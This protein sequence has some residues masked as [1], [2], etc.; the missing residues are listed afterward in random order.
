MRNLSK[1][2]VLA[3]T[4][5]LVMAFTSISSVKYQKPIKL[6]PKKVNLII[7]KP[8]IEP[9]KLNIVTK[10]HSDFLDAIG[11]KE[12][13][14]NYDIVNTFGYMGRYQFGASTLKGLGFKV[15]KEEFLNSPKIQ[16]QAMQALLEHNHKK[17]SR[18]ID[19]YC[20]TTVHGVYITESGV[21]AAAHLAG[22][23]NVRKFFRKG[24]KFKD[25]YGTTMVSYM[26]TFS[27]YQL[28]IY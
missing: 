27:G 14:N 19:K 17:L 11:K 16:E 10:N 12:S 13:G 7:E 2:P 9:V 15:T 22:A 1:L 25:G 8:Q 21:L 20:G 6:Q 23:G 4:V 28:D 18:Q 3:I 24:T 5:F 26:E